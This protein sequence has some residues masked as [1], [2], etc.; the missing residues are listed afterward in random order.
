MVCRGPCMEWLTTTTILDRLRDANDHSAWGSF[1]ER[2]RAPITG[3]SRKLGLSQADAEDVAQETLLAFMESYRKN[4]FER[5]RGRLSHY[6]FGIAHNKIL[7]A[8][9]KIATREA[10]ISVAGDG[11]SFWSAV[12]DPRQAEEAWE[13]EWRQAILAQC[14]EQVRNEVSPQ[15]FEAF[16]LVVFDQMEP[17][18][19]AERLAITRNAVFIAKHR[20]GTRLRDLRAAFDEE[21]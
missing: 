10:Q 12:P 4:A 15:T 14:L 16:R 8:R 11:T 3:F 7:M 21:Q 17:A 5:G 18:Q 1:V 2:F 20:V 9:R 6:L 19:V 13:Q